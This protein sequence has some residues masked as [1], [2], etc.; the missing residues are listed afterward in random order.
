MPSLSDRI[1]MPIWRKRVTT[2]LTL[3]NGGTIGQVWSKDSSTDDDATWKSVLSAMDDSGDYEV[4]DWTPTVTVSGTT[5]TITHTTQ[6]GRYQQVGER[7]HVVGALLLS[8]FSGNTGDLRIS[9]LPFT[10]DSNAARRAQITIGQIRGVT[11]SGYLIGT[12]E[13][14]TTYMTINDNASGA[15]VAAIN[16]ATAVSANLRLY[17]TGSYMV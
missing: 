15:A 13:N 1:L 8:A 3:F 5:G 12:V 7:C 9:G 2:F 16:A 10:S 4:G 14:S 17:F 11:F 6:V